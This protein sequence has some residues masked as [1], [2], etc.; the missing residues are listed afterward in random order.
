MTASIRAQ[1]AAIVEQLDAVASL[2]PATSSLLRHLAT[3]GQGALRGDE[4]PR[5]VVSAALTR[6]YAAG[7]PDLDRPGS[8]AADGPA[9]PSVR[10]ALAAALGALEQAIDELPE[11]P[12]DNDACDNINDAC[13]RIW[14]AQEHIEAAQLAMGGPVPSPEEAP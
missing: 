5:A 6:W 13:E 12:A 9:A 2:H 14:T 11:L 1:V 7:M 4:V 3:D 8:N 10:A